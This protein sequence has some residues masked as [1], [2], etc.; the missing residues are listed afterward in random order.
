MSMLMLELLDCFDTVYFDSF[1]VELI[2]R[3]IGRFIGNR[4][5][6]TNIS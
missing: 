5:L 4:N 2:P 6:Q 3:E 1:A